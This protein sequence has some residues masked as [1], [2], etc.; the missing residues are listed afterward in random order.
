MLPAQRVSVLRSFVG[1]S[2]PTF[3]RGLTVAALAIALGLLPVA[4]ALAQEPA[5]PSPGKPNGAAPIPEII[6]RAPKQKPKNAQRRPPP[7]VAAAT[8]NAA[9]AAQT[10]LD[11]TM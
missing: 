1:V 4:A 10:A 6:V 2:L 11:A 7:N 3:G 8:G 9:T 5:P